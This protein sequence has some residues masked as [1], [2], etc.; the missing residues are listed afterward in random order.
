MKGDQMKLISIEV[1]KTKEYQE[2]ALAYKLVLT[3]LTEELG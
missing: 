2:L 3:P 1:E